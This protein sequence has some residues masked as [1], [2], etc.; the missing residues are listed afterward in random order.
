MQLMTTS[1]DK[2]AN[3]AVEKAT[4]YITHFG[5][6]SRFAPHGKRSNVCFHQIFRSLNVVFWPVTVNL[7]T[8]IR[9]FPKNGSFRES[10][11]IRTQQNR[12]VTTKRS[13][14]SGNTN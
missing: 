4:F 3:N 7:A 2:R 12:T 11:G 5:F 8:D 1:W 6:Y 9:V 10:P 14:I 13:G